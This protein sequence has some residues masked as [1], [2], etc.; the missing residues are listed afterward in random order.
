[1]KW[2]Q[3]SDFSGRTQTFFSQLS[4]FKRLAL[5]VFSIMISEVDG[6]VERFAG[7]YM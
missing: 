7:K 2:S 5:P 4:L 1:M 6:I 3:R